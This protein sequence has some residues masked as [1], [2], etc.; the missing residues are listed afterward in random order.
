MQL[1]LKSV[2]KILS[3]LEITINSVYEWIIKHKKKKKYND[4]T[5]T[6]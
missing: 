5:K 2:G 1:I 6:D 3:A 4:R